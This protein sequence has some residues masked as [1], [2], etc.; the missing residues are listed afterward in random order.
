MRPIR[1]I[2][3]TALL[4]ACAAPAALI[5]ENVTVQIFTLFGLGLQAAFFGPM[6]YGIIPELAR[7]H[8]LVAGNGLVE[9][10]AFIGAVT[11][12]TSGSLVGMQPHGMLWVGLFDIV[13]AIGGIASAFLAPRGVPAAP[14]LRVRGTCS[15]ARRI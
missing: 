3:F 14:A 11:G 8:E 1:L 5:S 12:S 10:G 9:A 15:R 6:K 2:Q 4:L 7:Q 13:M